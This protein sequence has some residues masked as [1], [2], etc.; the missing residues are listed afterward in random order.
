MQI[1]A[2]HLVCTLALGRDEMATREAETG[3]NMFVYTT[4]AMQNNEQFVTK[5]IYEMHHRQ[6]HY[7]CIREHTGP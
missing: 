7:V 6:F 2:L 5:N 4:T 3:H 1:F